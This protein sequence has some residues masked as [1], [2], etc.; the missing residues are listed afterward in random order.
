MGRRTEWGG[1]CVDLSNCRD[2]SWN[3]WSE[4]RHR[5][6]CVRV[7]DGGEELGTEQGDCYSNE[8]SNVPMAWF[9]VLE[10]HTENDY[11]DTLR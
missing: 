9:A 10:S 6:D 8:R 7:R 3:S 1:E 4:G 11:S 2:E 5:L